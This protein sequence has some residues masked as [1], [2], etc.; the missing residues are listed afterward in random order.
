[1]ASGSFSDFASTCK[2]VETKVASAYQTLFEVLFKVDC[3][4]GVLRPSTVN[5]KNGPDFAGK[6]CSG[7][8]DTKNK[9]ECDGMVTKLDGDLK[10]NWGADSGGKVV[11][12][13]KAGVAEAFCGEVWG[14]FVEDGRLKGPA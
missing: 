4:N 5:A 9:T 14:K 13:G 10:A 6:M 7:L 12:G 11:E 2:P 8:E 1:M 3:Q